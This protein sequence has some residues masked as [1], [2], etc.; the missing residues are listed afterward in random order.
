[1]QHES[2]PFFRKFGLRQVKIVRG[3]QDIVNL[4]TENH[5]RA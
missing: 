1:M 5:V 2:A 4:Q 3:N